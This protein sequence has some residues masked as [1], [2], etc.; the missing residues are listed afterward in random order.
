M[1]RM[2]RID[3]TRLRAFGWY[4]SRKV[5]KEAYKVY[6]DKREKLAEKN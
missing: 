2:S 5:A 3:K 1:D 6:P 4:I